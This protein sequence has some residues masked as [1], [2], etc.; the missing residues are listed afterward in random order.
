MH[1]NNHNIPY[2][3][4]GFSTN[5]ECQVL[6]VSHGVV[7]ALPCRLRQSEVN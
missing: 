2:L 7:T 4:S 6:N 1:D 3:S 5:T